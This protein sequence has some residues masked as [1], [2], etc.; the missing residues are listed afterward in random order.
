M[1]RVGAAEPFD[2]DRAQLIAR[3][4]HQLGLG[5][6]AADERDLRALSPQRVGHRQRRHD[7]P[8]GPPAAITIFVCVTAPSCLFSRVG[9]RRGVL[10]REGT[11]RTCAVPPAATFSSSPIAA[12]ITIR[13][14]EP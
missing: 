3:R 8:R 14:V 4:G 2:G 7:V 13:L 9:H 5:A 10:P 6:R 1:Q 12:S 11:A